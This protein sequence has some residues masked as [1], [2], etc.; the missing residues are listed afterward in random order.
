MDDFYV[1][2][3]SFDD[4]LAKL[5]LVLED[6]LDIELGKISLHGKERYSVGA[7]DFRKRNR[8]RQS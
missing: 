1:F 7:P 8:G 6:K 5:A 2:G 4:C 3:T